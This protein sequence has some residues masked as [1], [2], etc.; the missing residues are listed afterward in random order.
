MG[1]RES[2][3]FG[4][5]LKKILDPAHRQL[6]HDVNQKI[7][8]GSYARQQKEA[9]QEFAKHNSQNIQSGNAAIS[10]QIKAVHDHYLWTVAKSRIPNLL[11]W[12]G[13]ASAAQWFFNIYP[14]SSWW[15]MGLIF[16]AQSLIVDGIH[17]LINP[18]EF[19]TIV[20]GAPKNNTPVMTHLSAAYSNKLYR[21]N[22]D[23]GTIIQRV[24]WVEDQ[25]KSIGNVQDM[26]LTHGLKDKQPTANHFLRVALIGAMSLAI[27]I[28]IPS[29]SFWLKMGIA[30]L[31]GLAVG[32]QFYRRNLDWVEEG[33]NNMQI[34]CKLGVGFGHVTP[35]TTDSCMASFESKGLFYLWY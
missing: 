30:T 24:W 35:S 1:S 20:F 6:L 26:P 22:P 8:D 19:H 31:F 11:Y 3:M 29:P 13:I 28:S 5:P 18:M 16:S 21:E 25:F 27:Y 17:F 7:E 15:S 4:N 34:A 14:G 23:K 10:E 32:F 2:E 12:G 9:L 33:A